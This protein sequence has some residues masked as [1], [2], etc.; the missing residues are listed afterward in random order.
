M[1][2]GWYE[3]QEIARENGPKLANFVA[4]WL[5]V[6]GRPIRMVAHSLGAQVVCAAMNVLH[7]WGYED[8]VSDLVLLG[9]ATDNEACAV[10]GE[11]GPG[12]GDAAE[13][14]VNGY[15][16]DDAVLE[17]TYSIGEFN[18]AVGETGIE[19]TPP[20]NVTEVDVTEVVPDHYSYPE[21]KADA[22]CMDVVVGNW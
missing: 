5:A 3:A 12:L 16:T 13:S 15:K 11:F 22:G 6:D 7:D 4:D 8:A 9:G 10:D 2:Q 20:D 21:L 14:V 17:W 1:D 19:G 18:R